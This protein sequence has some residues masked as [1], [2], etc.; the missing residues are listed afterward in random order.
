MKKYSTYLISHID[1]LRA[2]ALTF[3]ALDEDIEIK[4]IDY[5]D[6]D[7]S[8]SY[9]T[10]NLEYI[11]LKKGNGFKELYRDDTGWTVDEDISIEKVLIAIFEKLS[12]SPV[13]KDLL[14]THYPARISETIEMK[15]VGNDEEQWHRVVF[16]EKTEAT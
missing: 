11:F 7:A 5:K 12:N 3:D 10:T 6:G 16:W 15:V 13:N 8:T 2:I 14:L 9:I 4:F 1:L